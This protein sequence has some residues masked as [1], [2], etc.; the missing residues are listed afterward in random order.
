MARMQSTQRVEL[1]NAIIHKV[2]S[3]SSSMADVIEAL[4]SQMQKE[5]K[6]KVLWHENTNQ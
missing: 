2:I 6:K 3:S 1:M 4:D 5:E